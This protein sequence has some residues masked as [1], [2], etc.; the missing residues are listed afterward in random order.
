MSTI[1]ES[2]NKYLQIFDQ[3]DSLYLAL[4]SNVGG[5]PNMTINN[6]TDFNIGAI[7]NMLEWN[8]RLTISLRDQ[9][10]LNKATGK[11]LDLIT[12]QHIGILRFPGESIADFVLRIQQLIINPKV[13]PASIIYHTRQFSSPAD[14]VIVEGAQDSA[15][16]DVT[17][18]DQYKSF[19]NQTP[20]PELNHWILPA[21]TVGSAGGLYFFTLILENTPNNKIGELVDWVDRLIAAGVGYEIQINYTP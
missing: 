4:L 1:A 17:F 2:V 7:A 10:Y 11:F 19:K 9:L 18:S 16:A 14:P 21:I 3:S 15:F 5:V 20:G 13:S 6:P 8:R 12:F